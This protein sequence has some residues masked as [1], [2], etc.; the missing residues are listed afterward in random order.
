VLAT[1]LAEYLA[2]GPGAANFVKLVVGLRPD[3]NG[4]PTS[5]PAAFEAAGW[6][7]LGMLESAW[8]K[9]AASPR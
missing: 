7:D 6:K 5:I 2:Y 8:R 4:N 9:W 3:E 1:S